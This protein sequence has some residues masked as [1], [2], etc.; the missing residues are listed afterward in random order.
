MLQ[1]LALN[2]FSLAGADRYNSVSDFFYGLPEHILLTIEVAL[3]WLPLTFHMVYGLFIASRAESNYFS[4]TYKWSQNRMYWLQ[5]AS[6]ILLVVFLIFHFCTTTLQVK[7]HGNNPDVVSY[8]AMRAQFTNFGYAVFILYLLGVLAASYH[9]CYGLWNFCIRW[10]ITVGEEAQVRVQ[11]FSLFVF[12]V[13]T[14][15]GWAA[16]AGFL[17]TPPALSM[18]V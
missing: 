11:K 3:V 10:G 6:G 8:A 17:Q 13:V 9:L 5:R 18:Q 14:L 4:S 15:L 7:L 2:S 12:I 16:L 1:H